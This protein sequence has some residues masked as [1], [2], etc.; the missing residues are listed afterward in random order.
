MKIILL[1]KGILCYN[2]NN[3]LRQGESMK[4]IT[5]IKKFTLALA[6]IMTVFFTGNSCLF[7][8]A[9][10]DS[11]S[12]MSEVDG[13]MYISQISIPGTHDAGTQ[14]VTLGY[15]MR[16][17]NTSIS[18][19][20]NNGYRYIDLRVHIE[21]NEESGEQRL[22]IVHN[23]AKCRV[24]LNPLSEKLYFENVMSSIYTF[25]D[26]NPTEAVLV[27]IKIEDDEHS[28]S[29]VQKLIHKEITDNQSYWYTENRI[30]KLDE[31]RGKIVLLTRFDDEA[32]FDETGINLQWTEQNN[33]DVVDLPYELY[34]TES[35][36][37]WVQDR[38]KYSVEDKYSAV[39]DGLEN[40]E[41]DENTIF[42][43]FVSTSGSGKVGHPKGYA[44]QLNKLLLNYA[45]QSETS[46]GIV[47][48]DFG[49]KELAQH[50]YMTN[51]ESQWE[52]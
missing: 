8:D 42:L 22:Q 46:Y 16:C 25:I 29:D 28:I 36:R 33:V 18:Q 2:L 5:Q 21:E 32:G 24:S 45:F 48:V 39:V 50:I 15:V 10:E 11:A 47:I 9:K 34:M 37:L 13:D 49:T 26:A 14:F 20:L 30:P 40:C 6:V 12:W 51:F 7:A 52:E 3:F 43:N 41:A 27:N 17:Q 4:K 23:F 1:E 35:G 31:V 19:Q 44:R 38:Y